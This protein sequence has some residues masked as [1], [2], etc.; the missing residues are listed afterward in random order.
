MNCPHCGGRVRTY[1][2]PFPTVD[3]IIKIGREIVLIERKNPPLGW[4]LPGGFVDWGES[5]EEAAV[6][7]AKEETGLDVTLTDQFHTYSSPDR[8]PRFHTISTVYTATASGTPKGADD[9]RR[10]ALFTQKNLPPLVFD[11]QKILQNY[12]ASLQ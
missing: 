6:R 10:A 12:F 9:A 2:N 1:K 11:H 5:L 7:E 4:A 8:D 3:I